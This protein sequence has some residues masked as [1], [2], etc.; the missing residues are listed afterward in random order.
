MALIRNCVLAAAIACSALAGTAS[1]EPIRVKVGVLN[2]M[3][4]VY[5]DTGGPGSVVAARLAIEDFAKDSATT[6]AE[7]RV[8]LVS[9]DHQNKPDVGSGIA[10]R[11]FDQEGVDAIV[12]LPNSGVALAVAGIAQE[13]HKVALASSSMTSD[14]TGAT[15]RPTTVQW[16]TD[17]W[18]QGASTVFGM[19]AQGRTGGT[20]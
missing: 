16:V 1:A 12:D 17:T 2:D 8:D 6:G 19:A 3:S 18:A 4:G 20:S 15:C 7:V 11:W 5:S 14:L 10:R 9:A 13:R